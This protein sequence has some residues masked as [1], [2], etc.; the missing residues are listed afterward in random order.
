MFYINNKETQEH[1]VKMIEVLRT[2]SQENYELTDSILQNAY[3]IT[4][5]EIEESDF[6]FIYT[7]MFFELYF[8]KLFSKDDDKNDLIELLSKLVSIKQE[9][10]SNYLI[11]SNETILNNLAKF[12]DPENEEMKEY[13]NIKAN[14]VHT[15]YEE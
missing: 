5:S 3:D 11:T 4:F 7:K 1:F 9:E 14:G 12:Y 10:N 8:A 13:F 2:L 6:T 15:R